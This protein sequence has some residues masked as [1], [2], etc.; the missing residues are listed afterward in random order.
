MPIFSLLRVAPCASHSPA[1]G[2]DGIPRGVGL[3][4][5]GLDEAWMALDTAT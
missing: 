4:G 2:G 5:R 3:T 1:G